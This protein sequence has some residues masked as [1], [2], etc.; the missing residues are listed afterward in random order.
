MKPTNY[1][2][3]SRVHTSIKESFLLDLG[4]YI[5]PTVHSALDWHSEREENLRLEST[6]GGVY[7]DVA[8]VPGSKGRAKLW[9]KS[10]HGGVTAKIVRLFLFS[11]F[12]EQG[13]MRGSMIAHTLRSKP[14]PPPNLLPPH[15]QIHV[16]RRARPP[17]PNIP[18]PPCPHRHTRLHKVL[19]RAQCGFDDVCRGGWD[20][21]VFFG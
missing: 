7:A 17:P 20:E 8:I 16:W 15:R 14:Q 13:L 9:M 5:P 6:H 18:G 1:V 2:S 4:L 21:A 10:T 19:R 11:L 3:V 12:L